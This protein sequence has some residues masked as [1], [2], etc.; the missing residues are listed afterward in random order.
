MLG[1]SLAASAMILVLGY[2][3][4]VVAL[5]IGLLVIFLRAAWLVP[6]LLL[7]VCTLQPLVLRVAPAETLLQTGVK[8]ADELVLALLLPVAAASLLARRRPLLPLPTR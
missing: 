1:A 4:L 3:S 8:R 5:T 7:S 6:I 2:S